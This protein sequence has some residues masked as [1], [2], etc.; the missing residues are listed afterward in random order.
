[1]LL[2]KLLNTISYHRNP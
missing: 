2:W 1:M